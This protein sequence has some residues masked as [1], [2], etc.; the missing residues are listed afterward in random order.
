VRIMSPSSSL[1]LLLLSVVTVS[2]SEPQKCENVPQTCP[3]MACGPPGI[4]GFPGK[5]GHDGAKGEK[6]EP[7]ESLRGLQGPPG[8]LGPPGIQGLPGMIGPKG[9]KGDLGICPGLLFSL[10]TKVGKK[11]FLKYTEELTFARVKAL[12]SQSGGSVAT[13]QN[14][15]ENKAIKNI[16]KGT[17]FLG[18]TDEKTEGQFV[19]LSGNRQTYQNWDKGEPNNA[20]S[21]ENCVMVRENGKWNDVSCSSSMLAV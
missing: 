1:P 3:V 11:I 16:A 8:K 18:I 12:C 15:A 4:N 7:G 10:S 17:A 6:G 13:P 2:C 19:T 5:D 14:E 21:G 9:Q 20:D